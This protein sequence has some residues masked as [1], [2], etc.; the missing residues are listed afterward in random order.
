[1]T[2]NGNSGKDGNGGSVSVSTPSTTLFILTV[3]QSLTQKTVYVLS[4][5]GSGNST[6]KKYSLVEYEFR[7][8]IIPQLLG[9]K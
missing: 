7:Q 1:V 4:L 6:P 5:I 2:L 8:A 3:Q 9:S